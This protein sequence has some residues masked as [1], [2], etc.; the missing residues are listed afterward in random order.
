MREENFNS[1]AIAVF[2]CA[3]P[4]AWLIPF[5]P[6]AIVFIIILSWLIVILGKKRVILFELSIY[7]YIFI[8]TTCFIFLLSLFNNYTESIIEY[9]TFFLVCGITGVFY[10]QLRFSIRKVFYYLCCISVVLVYFVSQINFGDP[11]IE[12]VDYG[13]WMGISYGLLR[14]VLAIIAVLLLY[15]KN[16]KQLYIIILCVTLIFYSTIYFKYSTR[17]ALFA[18]IFFLFVYY[19]IQGNKVIRKK[20][21]L[22]IACLGAVFV[23]FNFEFFLS[24]LIGFLSVF[25]ISIKALDKVLML[26]GSGNFDN[27]RGALIDKALDGIYSS[28]LFGNGFASFER[29]YGDGYYVHNFFV[30]ILYEGGIVLFI[31][32]LF[33]L[34]YGVKCIFTKYL[35]FDERIFVLFLFCAG[36]I[37]LFF[38]SVYWK[39]VFFWFFIFY[40]LRLFVRTKKNSL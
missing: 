26:S 17:G 24:S 40:C 11:S 38:S 35:P 39:S 16:I 19:F 10:S 25:G 34:I 32:I 31:P 2:L 23:V 8:A 30:Q 18:I 3:N 22:F 29:M 12:S 36:I 21:M 28:P 37:E 6:K 4:I 5:I 15:R 7:H 20:I 13:M 9:F 27:G 33:I 14:L 1:L